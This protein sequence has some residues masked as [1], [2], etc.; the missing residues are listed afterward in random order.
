MLRSCWFLGYWFKIACLANRP[1]RHHNR[2]QHSSKRQRLR[3]HNPR[4]G[5]TPRRQ[6]GGVPPKEG[7]WRELRA[8]ETLGEDAVL[9]TTTGE[10]SLGIGTAI[11]V[12]VGANSQFRIK[13]L[14]AQL[15]K[16]DL[17][18][19][20]VT[21]NISSQ[22]N[23]VKE[24]LSVGVLGRRSRPELP[25]GVR[26]YAINKAKLPSQVTAVTFRL[27]RMAPK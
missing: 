25:D 10:V 17:E 6:R 18:Q 19:G 27:V 13:E 20:L 7:R 24:E 14:T 5:N 9:R 15:S 21:A 3:L 8:D 16:V 26:S 11:E 23:D 4:A 1:R 12:E 2:C 22:G